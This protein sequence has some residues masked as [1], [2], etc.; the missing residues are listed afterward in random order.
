MINEKYS[1]QDFSN[2]KFTDVAASEFNNTTIVGSNFYQEFFL[3]VDVFPNSVTGVTFENCN[4]DNV[5]IPDGC[6]LI[7]CSNRRIQIQNDGRLWELGNNN[8]PVNCITQDYDDSGNLINHSPNNIPAAYEL[9]RVV[10]EFQWLNEFGA[11]TPEQWSYFV[12]TPEKLDTKTK[13]MTITLKK[14]FEQQLQA[15][16]HFKDFVNKFAVVKSNGYIT[17]EGNMDMY[18]IKGKAYR[19]KDKQGNRYE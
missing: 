12:S 11:G 15:I 7:N 17:V 4:L 5:V 3:D 16:P 6:T 19:Y 13:F 18:K 1:R 9:E 14:E 2:M 10:N 8:K